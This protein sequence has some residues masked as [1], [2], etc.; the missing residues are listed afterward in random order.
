MVF[1]RLPLFCY[2]CGIIS[3]TEINCDCAW[4]ESVHRGVKQYGA[5]LLASPSEKVANRSSVENFQF[6][7]NSFQR[8]TDVP[9]FGRVLNSLSCP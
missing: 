4:D 7:A 9:V 3:H 8:R 1:E 6:G 5:W 2:V